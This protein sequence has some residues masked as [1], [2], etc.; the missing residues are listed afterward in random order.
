MKRRSGYKFHLPQGPIL[1][2]IKKQYKCADKQE[3]ALHCN[4]PGIM[5]FSLRILTGYF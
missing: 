5:N 2:E 4:S 1:G 3:S